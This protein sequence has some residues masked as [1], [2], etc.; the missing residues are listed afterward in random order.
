M[1]LGNP[2]QQALNQ[3]QGAV[4]QPQTMTPQLNN[5]MGSLGQTA[6][7]QN[8]RQDN[9]MNRLGDKFQ[10]PNFFNRFDHKQ[11]PQQ[12]PS[13][14]QMPQSPI[15]GQQNSW[16]QG[17]PPVWQQFLS[18]HPEINNY[19]SNPQFQSFLSGN[20]DK[21]QNRP[22]MMHRGGLG[23][24]MQPIGQQQGIMATNNPMPGVNY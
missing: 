22:D 19:T 5:Q 14:G 4:T 10:N 18:S 2:Y 16:M 9:L 20:I 13:I 21:L 17:L 12:N 24:Q 3:P 8:F 6:M 7:P 1:P 11:M 23:Q 15:S